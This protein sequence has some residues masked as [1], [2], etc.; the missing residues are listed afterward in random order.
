MNLG[1]KISQY[2]NSKGWSQAELA[3]KAGIAQANLSNIEK[4]KRD[5]TVSTLLRVADALEIKAAELLEESSSQSPFVLTRTRIESLAKAICHPK[6]KAAPEIREWVKVFRDIFFRSSKV[7]AKKVQEAWIKLRQQFSSEEIKS[8]A[9]RV[10]DEQQRLY[11][12]KS[13]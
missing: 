6:E 9:Q 4:G 8:V 7:S 11:A 5:V 13:D 2:R 3:A 12:Q 10:K 1:W